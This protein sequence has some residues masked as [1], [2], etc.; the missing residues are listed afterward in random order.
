M[1][2]SLEKLREEID[3]LDNQLVA[4]LEQ[5]MAVSRAIGAYKREN[6]VPALDSARFNALKDRLKGGS[7]LDPAFIDALYELIHTE[8]LKQQ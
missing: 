7:S 4:L 6:N 2:H 3:D 5:R 8:S 1:D